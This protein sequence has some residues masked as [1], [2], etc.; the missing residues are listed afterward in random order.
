MQVFFR[1]EQWS[2]GAREQWSN[3]A[4]EQW[5][6]PRGNNN[7]IHEYIVYVKLDIDY[8]VPVEEINR[9][10]TV[11]YSYLYNPYIHRL[12]LVIL[13]SWGYTYII[14]CQGEKNIFR[15]RDLSQIYM[16]GSS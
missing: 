9:V 15:K 11:E 1:L 14:K 6:H 2:N 10:W 16:R 3:G 4:M 12:V 8:Y 7:T 13:F 5:R